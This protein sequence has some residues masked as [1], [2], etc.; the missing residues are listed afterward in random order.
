MAKVDSFDKIVES[1]FTVFSRSDFRRDEVWYEARPLLVSPKILRADA[2][3]S[4]CGACC[5]AYTQDWLPLED[6]PSHAVNRM[7]E[8]DFKKRE[9]FTVWPK[10]EAFWCTHLDCLTGLC[11]IY[12][13]RPL[14]CEFELLRPSVT[15]A[16]QNGL[17]TRLYGRGWNMPRV[18]GGKGALCKIKPVS[19]KST[20]NTIK[21]LLR[22]QKWL[23]Y[24]EL[25]SSRIDEIKEW[26]NESPI[27]EHQHLF[28]NP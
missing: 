27:R 10:K 25:D 28:L 23:D 16:G 13:Q 7:V 18:D 14:T 11:T 12:N 5:R 2:C 26:I 15:Q 3:V 24:F 22:L 20:Q 21:R 17:T 8:I 19:L 4:N 6:Y 1:Y 9:I